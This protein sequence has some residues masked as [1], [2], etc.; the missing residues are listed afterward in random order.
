MKAG[1]FLSESIV[2]P[3]AGNG[4]PDHFDQLH[5]LAEWLKRIKP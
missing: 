5:A 2:R 3:S 1:L 4:A